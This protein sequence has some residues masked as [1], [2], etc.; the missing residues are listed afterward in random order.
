MVIFFDS[1]YI[2]QKTLEVYKSQYLPSSMVR[3][4]TRELTL[5]RG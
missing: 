3:K 1:P 2:N 5:K 4:I